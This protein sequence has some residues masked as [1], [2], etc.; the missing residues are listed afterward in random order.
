MYYTVLVVMQAPI[1]H[2]DTHEDKEATFAN[3]PYQE[4]G[5]ASAEVCVILC[6][7]DIVRQHL[8]SLDSVWFAGGTELL[9]SSQ[10]FLPQRGCTSWT[11]QQQITDLRLAEARG[12]RV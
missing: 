6:P 2:P 5:P 9:W 3:F 7:A 4:S 11:Q 8:T 12:F 1:V 10:G